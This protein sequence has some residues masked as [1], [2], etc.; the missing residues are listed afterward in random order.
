[1]VRQQWVKT[2]GSLFIREKKGRPPTEKN[3]HPT[4]NKL[5]L[6]QRKSGSPSSREF[7]NQERS[8]KVL[9]TE[10]KKLTS[11]AAGEKMPTSSGVPHCRSGE[12]RNIANREKKRFSS[13]AREKVCPPTA[14]FDTSATERKRN[15]ALQQWI[16]KTSF[17]LQQRKMFTFPQAKKCFHPC[18]CEFVLSV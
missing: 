5:V 12:K 3:R 8:R 18:G 4:K 14:E 6:Q 1:M 17:A 2:K 13:T 7:A 15:L 11:P 9:P 16:R 10:K